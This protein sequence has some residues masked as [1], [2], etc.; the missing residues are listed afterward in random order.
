MAKAHSTTQT[1]KSHI[2][3]TGKMTNFMDMEHC[4]TSKYHT[5]TN[6]SSIKTGITQKNIGSNIKDSSI[7]IISRAKEN[8]IY[9]MVKYS[10]A[11]SMKTPQ[12]E[13]EYSI[14]KMEP[15]SEEYGGKINS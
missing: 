7:W 1:T 11:T 9:P 13:K 14:G 12:M 8:G 4:T 5:S 3:A 6:H 10:K 2:K 15:E